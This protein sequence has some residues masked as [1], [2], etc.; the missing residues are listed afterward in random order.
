MKDEIIR[1]EDL[2]CDGDKV[3]V[4]EN[5]GNGYKVV[6]DA[7]MIKRRRWAI[8]W[9]SV[10]LFEPD[11]TYWSC[12]WDTGATEY[13]EVEFNFDMCQVWPHEVTTIEYR[14]TP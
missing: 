3:E 8:S 2:E 7:Q 11:G 13:Q 14:N 1:I 6:E 4:A 10:V 12:W 5:G 9:G